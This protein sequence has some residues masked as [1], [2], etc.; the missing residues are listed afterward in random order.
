MRRTKLVFPFVLTSGPMQQ[1]CLPRVEWVPS[2]LSDI[3]LV[4]DAI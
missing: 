2:Y 3:R 4:A 1:L